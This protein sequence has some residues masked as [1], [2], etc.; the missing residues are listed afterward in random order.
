[1]LVDEK[2][3]IIVNPNS[4]LY[5]QNLGYD[6]NNYEKI[7]VRIIDLSKGSNLLVKCRCDI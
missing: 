3:E 7:E 5:Y 2:I 4:R 1:M 6:C